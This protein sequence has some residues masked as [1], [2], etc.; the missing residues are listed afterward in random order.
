MKIKYQF[1]CDDCKTPRLKTDANRFIGKTIC[2]IVLQ[3]MQTLK[4]RI[5]TGLES[6]WLR[7][8]LV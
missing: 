5:R 6:D 1:I 8:G 3:K 2:N 4:R 7:I